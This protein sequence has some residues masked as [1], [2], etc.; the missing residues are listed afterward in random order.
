MLYYVPNHFYDK[1]SVITTSSDNIV[2]RSS[3]LCGTQNIHLKGKSIIAKDSIVRGDFAKIVI[4]KYFYLGE[5][6][7]IR[8]CSKVLL[9]KGLAFYP[10]HIGNYV[11]IGS[12]VVS[13]AKSI[14]SCVVVGDNVVIGSRVVIR[15]C[16]FISSGTVIPD[17]AIIAPFSYVSGVPYRFIRELP[18]GTLELFKTNSITKRNQFIPT[19]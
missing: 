2:S 17:D 19:D 15:D 6:S 7:V 12:N 9:D 5:S 8:P 11:T 4:G 10:L 14:G 16:V 1:S 13:N 3:L 18:E